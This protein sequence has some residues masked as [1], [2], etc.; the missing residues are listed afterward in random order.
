MGLLHAED[1]AVGRV[2]ELGT[3]LVTAGEIV[4]FA[5]QWDPQPFHVDQQAAADGA[6]GQLVASGLHT[7]GVFQRLAVL[8]TYRDWDI[9]AG[10]RI[11]SVELTAPV[12][13]GMTLAAALVIDEV[14][15]AGPERALV[16]TRGRLTAGRVQVLEAVFESYVRLTVD[17][18]SRSWNLG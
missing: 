9:I 6:F 5:R 8:G 15:P 17:P 1:L 10:R 18:A 3:Y 2:Y 13:A 7:L 11:R 4:E 12:T 14:R 16:V